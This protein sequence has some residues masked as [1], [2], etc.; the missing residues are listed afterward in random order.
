MLAHYE[1]NG[2]QPHNVRGA[3][4]FRDFLN[5]YGL[6]ELDLKGCAFTW[7]SN[8]RNGM[9][10]QEKLDRVI[11]NWPWRAEFCNAYVST[12]PIKLGSLSLGLM[13]ST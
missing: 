11:V 12:L 5:I 10:V 7:V 1:K 3:E 6:M 13:H 9:V 8:P 4:L 2:L